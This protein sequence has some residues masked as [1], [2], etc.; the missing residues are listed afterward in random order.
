M[1][2]MN[3]ARRNQ[4]GSG[5]S[6]ANVCFGGYHPGATYGSTLNELW[7]GTSWTEIND[8]NSGRYTHGGANDTSTS[9]LAFGGSTPPNVDGTAKTEDWNGA[10]L[11]CSVAPVRLGVSPPKAKAAPCVAPVP[12][13]FFLAVFKAPPV[14]HD[15]VL[16]IL[17][18]FIT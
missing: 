9:T 13:K 2:D 8:L 6:T 15:P 12:P 3:T 10:P 1:N 16:S 4:K 7:N 5:T 11:Y 14:D 17:N 18:P